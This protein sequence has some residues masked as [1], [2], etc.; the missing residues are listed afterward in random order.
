[1]N[2]LV[3]M[4]KSHNNSLEWDWLYL[5]VF[6]NSSFAWS[7]AFNSGWSSAPPA[8]Q[9]KRYVVTKY[10]HLHL[11]ATVKITSDPIDLGS[12]KIEVENY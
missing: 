8:P 2:M 7:V 3:S 5:A 6:P 1:M 11:C 10:T 12:D 9:F 4:A